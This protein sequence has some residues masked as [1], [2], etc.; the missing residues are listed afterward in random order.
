MEQEQTQALEKPKT[1]Y[2]TV[3]L[4]FMAA[5]VGVLV[6]V[7]MNDQAATSEGPNAVRRPSYSFNVD[8]EDYTVAEVLT[9]TA[10]S[11]VAVSSPS[12]GSEPGGAGSGVI[13]SSDG[14]VLTNAHVIGDNTVVSLQLYD[15]TPLKADLIGSY[16][17]EDIALLQIENVPANLPV[18]ELGNSVDA[19]VGDEVLAIGNT[20]NLGVSPTVTRGIVSGKDRTLQAE[21]G[22]TLKNLLQTDS[23]INPGN[24]GGPLVNSRGKVIGI[25]TAIIPNANSVGFAIPIDSIKP[26]IESIRSGE[27]T[28]RS[29]QAFF[30]VLSRP[31]AG[32]TDDIR[33]EYGV[34]GN[35]GVFV[36]EIVPGAAAYFA[37]IKA[38]DVV[39]SVNGQPVESPESLASIVRASKVGETIEVVVKRNGVQQT[40]PVKLDRRGP[41]TP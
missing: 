11:V 12:F 4:A 34:D 22:L 23:A 20:L 32:L 6:G 5:L 2:T 25:N 17:E 29:D 9:L 31:T 19:Q 7:S 28:I 14:T 15:G 40:V 38:G 24:S 41:V 30:G 8:E 36:V 18:A 13:I 1:S 33:T 35:S 16:P 3:L 37:G 27:G 10:P 21:G 39:L 26:L